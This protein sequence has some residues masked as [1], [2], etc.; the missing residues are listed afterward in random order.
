[1]QL[2]VLLLYVQR[3]AEAAADAGRRCFWVDWLRLVPDLR[4]ATAPVGVWSG[5]ELDA[6]QL[7]PA[8]VRVASAVCVAC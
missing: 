2:T 6:F 1:V 7:Q 5:G 8:K 4:A 3:L